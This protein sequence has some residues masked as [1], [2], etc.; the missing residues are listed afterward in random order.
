M[1]ILPNDI[2]TFVTEYDWLT[3]IILIFI[4]MLIFH[5]FSRKSYKMLLAR[6]DNGRHVW[7]VSFLYS[8]H[9]PWLIFFW[10]FAL[11]FIIPNLL[12]HFHVDIRHLSIV[13][14][15][16]S[17]M[18]IAA[19][20]WS[21]MKFI[22]KMKE[23]IVPKSSRIKMRD[24]T[25]VHAIT[26]LSRVALTVIVVLAILPKFGFETSSLLA[27]G[28][29]GGIGVAFAAKDLLSN[30]FG[31]MMIYWDRP[32]SVGDWIRSPDRNIEGTVEYI[33]WRL[34]RIRTFSKRPLYVPNS[35]FSTI[36][37]EN[38]SRM[39]NRQITT[40][41]GVRY[42]DAKQVE[43][44]VSDTKAMLREHPGIDQTQTLMVHFVEFAASSLNINLYVF[45]KTTDWAKYRDVQQDVFL[46]TIGIITSHGAECAFPTT[47]VQVPN[48][49]IVN[50][51]L[52]ESQHV[53]RS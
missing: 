20:Y 28:G 22:T 45:T 47:T 19:L 46:K 39:T 6:F 17:L 1:S 42:D 44:I 14:E 37:I 36:S 41:I 16:R 40:M 8:V 38:P 32:F 30:F 3:R 34:T 51:N 13:N 10:L 52:G 12:L 43:A 48:P 5:W 7:L 50:Q 35:V 23:E 25:T 53:T 29:A 9:M 2:S 49:V 33:G 27:F 31:G 18:F 26:Q 21:L 11:S 24:K 15:L 4:G